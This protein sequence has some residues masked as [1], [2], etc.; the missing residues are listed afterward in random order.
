MVAAVGSGS[1][2]GSSF[3]GASGTASSGGNN[4]AQIGALQQQLAGLQQQLCKTDCVQTQKAL[5]AQIGSVEAKISVL[6]S[7]ASASGSP[8]STNV[9]IN[10]TPTISNTGTTSTQGNVIN[11][12]A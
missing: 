12:L 3:Y 5:T 4:Q 9:S 1:I 11:T 6:Q 10:A 2:G 7:T 8:S